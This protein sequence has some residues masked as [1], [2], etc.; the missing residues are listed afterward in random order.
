MIA[1]LL[2][3]M[4]GQVAVP[5]VPPPS[6]PAQASATVVPP[7]PAATPPPADEDE[8][9]RIVGGDFADS[10]DAPWQMQLVWYNDKGARLLR[11]GAVLIDPQ[12]VLTARHC[13]LNASQV[14]AT[15]ET[16]LSTYRVRGGGLLTSGPMQEFR[17]LQVVTFGPYANPAAPRHWAQNDILLLRLDRQAQ[18]TGPQALT[19]VRLPRQPAEL[20]RPAEPVKVSGWG[21]TQQREAGVAVASAGD[22]VSDRLKFAVVEM[23]APAA[24]LAEYKVPGPL[25]ETVLCARFD[26][27]ALTRNERVRTSCQGDSGGPLVFESRSGPVLVGIVSAAKG[28]STYPTFYANVAAYA[29]RIRQAIAAG[30]PLVRPASPRPAARP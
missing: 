23:M 10:R 16:V 15:D 20:P 25:P 9:G 28:C 13:T 12:W 2:A 11:C 7:A 26:P 5:D 27:T 1:M 30:P 8:G 18:L 6:S 17:I 14:P 22:S 19:P 29:D 21:N 24:C 3:L 4:F